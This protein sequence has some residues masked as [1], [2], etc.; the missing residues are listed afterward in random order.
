[1]GTSSLRPLRCFA[2][3]KRDL[4]RSRPEVKALIGA[5]RRSSDGRQSLLEDWVGDRALAAD[6]SY[7]PVAFDDIA[8]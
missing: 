5:E 3:I 1:V 8:A 7:L 6:Q 2:L 4:R